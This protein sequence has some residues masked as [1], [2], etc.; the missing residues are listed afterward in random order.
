MKRSIKI[1]Q[2][3]DFIIASDLL[4]GNDLQN[5][6][7]VQII[8]QSSFWNYGILWLQNNK[9]GGEIKLLST[10]LVLWRRKGGDYQLSTKNMSKHRLSKI[11]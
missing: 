2:Q 5:K 11:K 6:R 7:I 4:G 1:N 9:N 8:Q 10:H 3:I